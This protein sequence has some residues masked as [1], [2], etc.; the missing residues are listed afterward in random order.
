L[1]GGKGGDRWW[2]MSFV[3]GKA[4]LRH[5]NDGFTKKAQGF[6]IYSGFTH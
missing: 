5:E 1:A 6:T 2:L 4:L 3:G